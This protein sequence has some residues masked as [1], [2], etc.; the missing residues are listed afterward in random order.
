MSAIFQSINS[1]IF[2][3]GISPH[4]NSTKHKQIRLTNQISALL[5]AASSPYII[6]LYLLNKPLISYSLVFIELLFISCITLNWLKQTNISRIL[7]VLIANIATF[8][9]STLFKEDAGTQL[10]FFSFMAMPLVIFESSE[11]SKITFGVI[12][13]VIFYFILYAISFDL[14]YS[15]NLLPA[16]QS[17]IFFTVSLVSFIILFLCSYF[18]I[19]E[20]RTHL[21]QISQDAIALKE[22]QIQEKLLKQAASYQSILYQQDYPQITN[23]TFS[24]F[25][26]ASHYISGDYRYIAGINNHISASIVLDVT[27]HGAP[28]AMMTGILS[29]T[30]DDLFNTHPPDTLQNPSSFMKS[31]NQTLCTEHRLS[32]FMAG[33]YI[34]VD[35]NANVMHA[36]CAGA[37]APM[38]YR[39]GKIIPIPICN[40][41]LRMDDTSEFQSATLPIKNGDIIIACTDGLMDRKFKTGSPVFHTLDTPEGDTTHSHLDYTHFQHILSQRHPDTPMADHIGDTLDTLCTPASDDMTIIAIEVG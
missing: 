24:V 5:I 31:L 40:D 9:Y 12:C 37:E 6:L 8:L 3:A 1:T 21:I 35:T 13:P 39:D 19:S 41:S 11:K 4:T 14:G 30:V 26:S 23:Q 15:A 17:L 32:K 28:A 22:K 27:G 10:L 2:N 34:V 16:E 29:K 36:T 25:G 18:L 33:V 20:N 7:L 38:I